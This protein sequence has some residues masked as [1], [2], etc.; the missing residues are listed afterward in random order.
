[1]VEDSASS[2]SDAPPEELPSGAPEKWGRANKNRPSQ[3]STKK[4]VSPY[5]VAPG[6]SASTAKSRDPRF[7][8][9]AK[10]DEEA[11]KRN[12]DFITDMQKEEVA[13]AKRKLEESARA[14]HRA[15]QRGGGAKRRRTREK[16]LA[17]DEADA[18]KLE[19]ERTANRLK[20]EEIFAKRERVKTDM[21]REEVAAVKEGKKP[22][23]AKKSV[24][25]ERELL[26]QYDELRK[27]G[28]LE[29]F[30]EKRRRKNSSAQKRRLPRALD[31]RGVPTDS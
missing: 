11:W 21:R 29:K 5:R 8:P 9:G 30:L 6:L 15:S 14:A 10:V 2:D 20:Q 26:A 16:V 31:G 28:N 25:R 17:P 4:K 22:F 19:L 7:D 12:Y 1:M 24:I 27:A 23:F 13:L 3:L 18:L